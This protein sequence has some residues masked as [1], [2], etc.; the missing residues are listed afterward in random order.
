MKRQMTKKLITDYFPPGTKIAA[1]IISC[2]FILAVMGWIC[3]DVFTGRM[4]EAESFDIAENASATF[5]RCVSGVFVWLPIYW[6]LCAVIAFVH[7]RSYYNP[8]KSIYVMKRLPNRW[9]LHRRCLTF[10]ILY[11]LFALLV[12]GME[13]YLFI[14]AYQNSGIFWSKTVTFSIWKLFG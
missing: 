13:L 1:E 12:F 11:A 2:L 10:P 14:L 3:I 4:A 6:C 9:E 8:V 5:E 7:Y